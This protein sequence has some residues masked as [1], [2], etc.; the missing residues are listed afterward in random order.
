MEAR[1]F[2]TIAALN[3]L[4]VQDRDQRSGATVIL[5]QFETGVAAARL[6]ERFRAAGDP[7]EA[8]EFASALAGLRNKGS[9]GA[10]VAALT[11]RQGERSAA[12]AYHLRDAGRHSRR[13][14]RALM[15]LVNDRTVPQVV[16]TE[17]IES[18]GC[19]GSRRAMPVL[20]CALADPLPEVRFW[21]VYSLGLF[22]RSWWA[23]TGRVGAEV[24]IRSALDKMVGDEAAAPT[25]WSV[26]REAQAVL[27][28]PAALKA[29]VQEVL[30]NPDATD[31]ER[32]WAECYG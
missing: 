14:L 3:E 21:A 5:N 26:G 13:A 15:Q 28:E 27:A 12:A 6:A 11:E 25:W 30:E 24:E 16:R 23:R 4:A 8:W 20:L 10:L 31:E 1:G 2:S 19:I 22:L 32:R 17:A 29:A 9:L 7:T 18:L